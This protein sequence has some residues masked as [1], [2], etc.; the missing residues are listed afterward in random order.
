MEAHV[1][2]AQ[3][4]LDLVAAGLDVYL[5]ADSVG[6]RET[7]ARDIAVERLRAAGAMIV[8]QEMVAFE[9]LQRGDD[10]AFKDVVAIVK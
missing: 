7:S 8:A 5:V 3:T 1:C 4:A 6:S 2:V 10:P 9:W